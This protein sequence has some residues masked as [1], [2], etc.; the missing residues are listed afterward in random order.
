MSGFSI[1][2]LDLREDADRRARDSNLLE[3]ARRWLV[4][5]SSAGKMPL[6]LDLGAG[7][8]STLRTLT[9]EGLQPKSLA[10]RL[11][12]H[13]EKLLAE[14]RRRHSAEHQMEICHADLTQIATLPMQDANMVT[15]SALFDLVSADFI[16]MLIQSLPSGAA[17]Y[18]ALNYDGMTAWTPAHPLD[19]AVLEAFNKDQ[20]R[21]K[22]F[23]VA[24]GPDAGAQA[25]VL[26]SQAGYT[27]HSASSPWKLNGTDQLMASTLIDGIAAAVAQDPAIDKDELGDWI[28][29]RQS[30]VSTGTCTVG[31]LDILALPADS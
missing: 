11:V 12:D 15:A 5:E 23:G 18:A 8:G 9:A 17:V 1:D 22:G 26:F 19:A 28:D 31:H 14:A 21:D 20:R 3:Q 16:E 27:V 6:V 10:W 7:T 24:L 13:D 2:W 25:K 30:N 29:F 4:T